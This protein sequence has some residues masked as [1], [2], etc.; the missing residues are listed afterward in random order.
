[1][2]SAFKIKKHKL[3]IIFAAKFKLLQPI[4]VKITVK[5]ID[6]VS[7]IALCVD[8]NRPNMFLTP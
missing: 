7:T 5:I 6:I 3:M 4:K 8:G 1:M 2:V